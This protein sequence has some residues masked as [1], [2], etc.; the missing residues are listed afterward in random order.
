MLFGR[1]TVEKLGEC[2]R[3]YSRS[4]VLLV[5]GK[6]SIKRTGLYGMGGEVL[7]P[8]NSILDPENTYTVSKEQTAAGFVDIMSHVYAMML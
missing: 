2:I 6:G 8:K 4:K 5:Y 7:F 3:N 1:N